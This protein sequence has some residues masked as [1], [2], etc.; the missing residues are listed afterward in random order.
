MDVD[1]VTDF[2]SR[3]ISLSA[4]LHLSLHLVPSAQFDV[5]VCPV[6]YMYSFSSSSKCIGS[7]VHLDAYLDLDTSVELDA[8]LYELI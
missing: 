4:H 7:S 8:S 2:S 5:F 1:S 3:G 6:I